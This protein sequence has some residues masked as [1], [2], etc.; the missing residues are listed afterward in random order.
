M[1]KT[2]MF[3]QRTNIWKVRP[4]NRDNSWKATLLCLLLDIFVNLQEKETLCPSR[5]ALI[6]S[7][8][9]SAS[10]THFGMFNLVRIGILAA[11]ISNNNVCAVDKEN[12]TEQPCAAVGCSTEFHK[13]LP[14]SIRLKLPCL[15]KILIIP[16]NLSLMLLPTLCSVGLRE[17]DKYASRYLYS[18]VSSICVSSSTHLLDWSKHFH[19]SITLDLF[20][21]KLSSISW[22][23]KRQ[24]Y[25]L[26]AGPTRIRPLGLT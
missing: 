17:R 11:W 2:Y 22:Q 18:F 26:F 12:H 25:A 6:G 16:F 1:G 7:N 4:F 23:M 20:D 13:A 3:K 24:Y 21:L 14:N 9:S 19:T 10:R 15:S 8:P 5:K